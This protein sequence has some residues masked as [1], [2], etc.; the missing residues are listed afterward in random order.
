MHGNPL[1]EVLRFGV[2]EK[3]YRNRRIVCDNNLNSLFY[4]DS[5]DPD[6]NYISKTGL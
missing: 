1:S 5:S 2:K 6:L 4:V 3:P